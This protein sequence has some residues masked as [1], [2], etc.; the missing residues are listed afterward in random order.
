MKELGVLITNCSCLVNDVQKIF[1]VY[2]DMGK[3]DAAI[4]PSWPKNYSTGINQQ[5]PIAVKF[6]DKFKMNTFFSVR[7]KLKRT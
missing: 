4:P 2:W 1:N 6:D 7:T 5:N 3:K